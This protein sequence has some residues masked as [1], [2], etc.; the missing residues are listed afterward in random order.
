MSSTEVAYP[1]LQQGFTAFIAAAE[2][3]EASYA[4]LKTRADQ[5]DL[6]LAESNERLTAALGE[7]GAL[8]DALP[9]GMVTI[10]PDGTPHHRNRA[11]VELAGSIQE[12][13]RELHGLEDGEHQLP[14]A[15]P[16]QGVLAVTVRR[17]PLPESAGGGTLLLVEDRSEV[18][19]LEGEVARLDRLA[20]L[21]ELALGIAHEIRN[22]LNGALGFAELLGRV[23]TGGHPAAGQITRYSDR[24]IQGLRQVE[25]IVKA[26]LGFAR[27]DPGAA[28]G[29][30]V[31]ALVQEAA[32]GAQISQQRLDLV[33][34]PGLLVPGDAVGRV[35]TNL[36][37][38]SVEAAGEGVRI[39]VHAVDQGDCAEIMVRDDG[40]GVPKELGQRIFVPFV[41]GKDEG[42]GL[43]LALSQRVL[44]YLGGKVEWIEEASGGGALFRVIAPLVRKEPDAPGGLR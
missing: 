28:A 2:Q 32:A 23:P 10:D 19:A 7:Q 44:H 21:S 13:G 31:Q 20:G 9:M 14:P 27:Q 3:L 1:D 11:A 18:V 22:P 38:N 16:G 34:D 39:K 25:G 43:G 42:H 6:A 26:L 29:V 17:V 24:V 40:P 15:E 30:T 8:V 41:S 5:V 35:L 33:G 12:R 37:R 4:A 36:F